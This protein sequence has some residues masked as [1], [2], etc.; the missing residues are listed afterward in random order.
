MQ[1]DN[2]CSYG[3]FLNEHIKLAAAECEQYFKAISIPGDSTALVPKI[4]G[5][6][7]DYKVKRYRSTNTLKLY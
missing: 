5:V 4:Q 7:V 1:Q 2:T 6:A 3:A